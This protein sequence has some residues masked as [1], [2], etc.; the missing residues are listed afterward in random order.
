MHR[1][2]KDF[3]HLWLA[4]KDDP[5]GDSGLNGRDQFLRE[6]G[7]EEVQRGVIW[8]SP[9]YR[10]FAHGMQTTLRAAPTEAA[11]HQVD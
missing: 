5:S 1:E 11:A 9:I 8:D 7:M 4:R 6:F 10:M 2:L 3:L